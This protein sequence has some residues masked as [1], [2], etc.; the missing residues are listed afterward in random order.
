[1]YC[2]AA[3][4][5][6]VDQASV[7]GYLKIN[8]RVGLGKSGQSGY[9]PPRCKRRGAPHSQGRIAVATFYELH[10]FGKIIETL[11]YFLDSPLGILGEF[12]FSVMAMK[13]FYAQ[14]IFQIFNLL[15][16]RCRRD[17]QFLGSS[18]EA[19]VARR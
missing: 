16:N 18:L 15:T 13:E 2:V 8:A 7:C 1:L 19:F 10:S 4:L 17:K 3:S 6:V 11:G 5:T 14:R 9:Q 12:N